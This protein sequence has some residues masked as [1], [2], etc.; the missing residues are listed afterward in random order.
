MNV[1][2]ANDGVNY[3]IEQA[4]MTTSDEKLE[5]L[6]SAIGEAG[7]EEAQLYLVSVAKRTTNERKLY[8]LWE[9]IGRASRRHS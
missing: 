9:A 2:Q 6:W 1:S 3:L 7:G 4:K 5:A 8:P